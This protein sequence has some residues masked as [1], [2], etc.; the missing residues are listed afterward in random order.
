MIGARCSCF[1]DEGPHSMDKTSNQSVLYTFNDRRSDVRREV[2]LD[3]HIRLRTGELVACRV[4]NVS[5]GGALVHLDQARLLPDEFSLSIP[6]EAFEA[7]CEVR[8]RTG[9]RVGVMFMSNRREAIAKF[10]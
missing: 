10:G 4:L 1:L 9:Q 8:H 3:A 6:S 7:A 2:D 5:A